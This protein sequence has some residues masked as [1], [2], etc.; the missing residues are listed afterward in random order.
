MSQKTA[1]NF[2]TFGWHRAEVVGT[3]I[4]VIVIWVI[5]GVLLIEA[6]RRLINKEKNVSGGLMLIVGTM[7]LIFNMI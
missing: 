4:S 7:G 5:T 2:L 1:D 6:F 3:L